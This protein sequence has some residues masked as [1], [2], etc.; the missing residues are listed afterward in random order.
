MIKIS[1]YSKVLINGSN[2]GVGVAS[3]NANTNLNVEN[4][5]VDADELSKLVDD[6]KE[7]VQEE[8]ITDHATIVNIIN[9]YTINYNIN[10]TNNDIENLALSIEQIQSVQ[11]DIDS[12]ESQVSEVLGNANT[13][14]AKGFLS[15]LFN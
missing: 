12:Y 15:G 10:L 14:S 3:S 2:V 11:G 4:S 9:N 1:D 13:D 6:V 5:D 7:T 8:D